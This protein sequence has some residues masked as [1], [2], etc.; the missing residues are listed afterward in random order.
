MA[1]KGAYS[2]GVLEY[3]PGNPQFPVL[4]VGPIQGTI[5]DPMVV[6]AS[7]TFEKGEVFILSTRSATTEDL[8]AD[9]FLGTTWVSPVPVEFGN[10]TAT[11]TRDVVLHNTRRTPVTLTAVDVSAIPGLSV[12]S[13]A[14]PIVIPPYTSITVTFEAT[15]Q[16]DPVIDDNVIFTVDGGDIPVRFTGRR[17]IIFNTIPQRPID[18]KVAFLTDRMIAL[19]GSE[20]VMALR[21]LP[22]YDVKI[23][24]RFTDDVERSRQLNVIN[25]AGF[26]RVGLQLWWQAR[27]ITTPATA[28]ATVVQVPTADCEIVAD[29]E[30][31]FVTPAGVA[32]DA[33]TVQSFDASSVTLESPVGIILPAGSQM[34][35]IKYGFL[36]PRGSTFTWAINAEDLELRFNLVELT[37][38][39][40]LDLS[41]FAEYLGDPLIIEPLWFSARNRRGGIENL[42]D[43]LDSRTGDI[44]SRRVELLARPGLQVLVHCRSLADQQAWRAFLYYIRGSWRPFWIPSG[45]DDLPLA[46]DLSLGGNTFDIV[47]QGLQE[48]PL[49]SP[50]RDLKITVQGV[51]Y[52]RRITSVADAGPNEVVTVDSVIPGAGTVPIADVKI[53]WLYFV[54]LEDDTASFR[55]NVLGTSD[56]RFTVKGVI[57]QS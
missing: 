40:A 45:T 8:F 57:D 53:S 32:T 5:V 12:I 29:Q 9:W 42:L 3:S 46:N 15:T 7:L 34:M 1:D 35:P 52:Y 17:L 51:D 16:G 37:D 2:F 39:G 13:A 47:N 10:I 21:R 31:S 41:Y 54:R 28:A 27:K 55:H 33:I 49:V 4:P 38:I 50:R 23:V 11:K 20:Q 25:A 56:L 48:V 24:Q 14:P 6:G 18:E 43:I 19:P 22:R 44:A 36:N 30:V 26:L